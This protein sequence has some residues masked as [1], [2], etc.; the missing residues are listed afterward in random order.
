MSDP[1]QATRRELLR[2]GLAGGFAAVAGCRGDSDDDPTDDE[3]TGTPGETPR[4][5]P[6]EDT[7]DTD[8]PTPE[9]TPEPTP[10][11]EQTPTVADE[12]PTPG[13]PGTH[14]FAVETV[15][16]GVS[17]PWG[18]TF[19]PD[20]QL[21]V[22][23]WVGNL[24]LVD[25]ED[26]TVEEVEGG[27][28]V[29]VAGQG[30]ML[31]VALHPSFPDPSWV[32]LTYS[33]P[34]SDGTSATALGRGRLDTDE[35]AFETFEQLHVAEP[36]VDSGAHFGSRCVF[37]ADGKLYMSSGDRQFKNFGP[38]HVAQD[39]TNELGAILRFDPDGSIPEDNPFVDD[40]DAVDSIYSYGHR[41][42]QGLAVHPET[43]DLWETEH[44]EKDGDEINII[45]AGENY[46]WPIAD[47]GCKYGTD[48]Q[49]GDSTDI[50]RDDVVGPV[51]YWECGT[52]G[53][54]PAGA[55]F[56]DGEAFPN[57]QGD[58]FVGN[59]AGAY[60]GRLHVRNPGGDVAV[61]ELDPLLTDRG[62]RV[63][64]VAVAPD[65]D[66]LYAAIDGENGPVVRLVPDS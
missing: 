46:G 32:Y 20:G 15:S 4:E 38:D 17:A 6:G 23:E 31:D 18:L 40:E 58:L 5:T 53:F 10:D 14:E 16:E 7:P 27:P 65:T 2:L 8:T 56:Y 37:G 52:G 62:W 36:Y 28:E 33:D 42:P 26:G 55:T 60:L 34:G 22:T 64:A 11:D 50:E 63:R 1:S 66:H 48:Q 30:G 3:P 61:E 43:D 45:R 21:L 59:L 51:Y 13:P 12:E 54:P 39:T 44:G 24:A 35:A 25:R 47:T 57:W 41:N 49:I 9:P 19:L 29:I